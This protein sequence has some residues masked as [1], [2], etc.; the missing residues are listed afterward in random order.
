MQ[1]YDYSQPGYYF[2]TICTKGRIE[3]FGKIGNGIM[4]LN[5]IGKIAETIWQQIPNSYSCV[6]LDNFVVMPNHLHGIIIIQPHDGTPR[7]AAT[8]L[9]ALIPNS[10]PSIVNHFKGAVKKQCNKNG[11]ADFQWQ[12]RFYDHVIRKDESLDKIREYIKNNPLKWELDRNNPD[13]MWV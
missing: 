12:S 5:Q 6:A 10:L 8:G 11:F 3:Y 1:K 13:G 7:R 2:V 9:D 4:N